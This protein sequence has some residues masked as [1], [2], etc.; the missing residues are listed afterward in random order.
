MEMT[1]TEF[2]RKGGQARAKKLGKQRR[3]QIASDAAKAR[4]GDRLVKP[5]PALT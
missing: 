2:A 5:K 4:W 1:I 3:K